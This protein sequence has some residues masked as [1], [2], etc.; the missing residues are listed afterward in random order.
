MSLS[1][2]S[3]SSCKLNYRIEKE[4]PE[5]SFFLPLSAHA[6]KGGGLF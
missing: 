5:G 3:V 1:V 4:E 2:I 6:E